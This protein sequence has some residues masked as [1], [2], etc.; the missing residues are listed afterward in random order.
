[1][2]PKFRF[3]GKVADGEMRMVLAE[4]IDFDNGLIYYSYHEYTVEGDE[5]V[6]GDVIGFEDCV[7]MQF[8]GIFDKNGNEIYEGDIVHAYGED[9]YLIGV[10]EYFDNAYCIK[11][12]NGIY[13]SLWTNAEQYEIIGN[14]WE[15]GELL[16]KF[17][18]VSIRKK[19]E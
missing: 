9:T 1:M 15:D 18:E 10:I 5:H 12:K 16:E 17:G 6:Y 8:I 2:K 14:I 19:G 13:N 11:N 3:F 4:S 7:L